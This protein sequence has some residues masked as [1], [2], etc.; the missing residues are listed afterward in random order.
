MAARDAGDKQV[1]TRVLADGQVWV[2][3]GTQTPVRSLGKAEGAM[4]SRAPPL[5]GS[6][7]GGQSMSALR[8][9]AR[10]EH[11]EEPESGAAADQRGPRPLQEPRAFRPQ[12]PLRQPGELGGGSEQSLAVVSGARGG[13]CAEEADLRSIPAPKTQKKKRPKTFNLNLKP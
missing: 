12:S 9:A 5:P 4:A 1:V 10:E 2:D 13:L 6:G 7:P 3:L 11:P 8:W